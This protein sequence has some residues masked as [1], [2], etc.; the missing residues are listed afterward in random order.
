MR[1]ACGRDFFWLA[2]ILLFLPPNEAVLPP[3]CGRRFVRI[4]ESRVSNPRRWMRLRPAAPGHNLQGCDQP[5]RCG[6]GAGKTQRVA[7]GCYPRV[8]AD[9]SS[10]SLRVTRATQ[11]VAMGREVLFS[12]ALKRFIDSL[13]ARYNIVA[14][15]VPLCPQKPELT[16]GWTSTGPAAP[17]RCTGPCG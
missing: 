8:T 14:G 17:A 2:P 1:W 7:M 10:E 13:T 5:A 9:D 3:P 15:G 16:R 6:R 12:F 4:V 11:R